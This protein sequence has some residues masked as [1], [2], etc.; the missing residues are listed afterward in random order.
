MTLKDLLLVYDQTLVKVSCLGEP[1]D[2]EI[3]GADCCEFIFSKEKGSL[4][5]I[6]QE[7]ILESEIVNISIADGVLVVDTEIIKEDKKKDDDK[8]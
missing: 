5:S 3:G 4:D 2:D 1:Y 8:D 7:K 6:L